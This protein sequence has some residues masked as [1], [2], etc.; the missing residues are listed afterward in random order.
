MGLENVNNYIKNKKSEEE[1]AE[2]ERLVES[3]RNRMNDQTAAEYEEYIK[4][5]RRDTNACIIISTDDLK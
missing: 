1:K 3:F 2:F 4:N 5:N